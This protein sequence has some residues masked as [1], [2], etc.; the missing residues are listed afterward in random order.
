MH[1]SVAAFVSGATAGAVA[2]TATYPLDLLRTRFAARGS[3]A[4]YRSFTGSI[5]QILR[6]EGYPGFFKGLP[7]SLVQIVPYMG[8]FFAVYEAVRS[9]L[10][11]LDLP[12]GGGDAVAGILASTIAKTGVFPL[13]LIRKRLQVQGPLRRHIAGGSVPEYGKGVWVTGRAILVSEG[14]RGL[15]KGLGISLIKAAPASAITMWSYENAL[16]QLKRW[17]V[18]T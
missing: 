14:W 5:A 8:L 10:R 16:R 1:Q 11:T 9:P 2:T 4:V 13:D 18:L 12:F 3:T 17:E 15:Y 6:E 7:A